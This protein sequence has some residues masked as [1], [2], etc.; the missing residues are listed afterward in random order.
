[1]LA[2][3]QA[4]APELADILDLFHR[5]AGQW[6]H[7]PGD[8]HRRRSTP[9]RDRVRS[10]I[11][12]YRPQDIAALRTLL[13]KIKKARDRK[14]RQR[15][16]LYRIEGAME[17]DVVY[18]SEDL[19]VRHIKNKQASIHYGHDTKWCISMTRDGY[20][21]EYTSHNATFFFFERKTPKRDAFDKVALL[22]PRNPTG[23][24]RAVGQAFDALD[25]QIDMFDLAEVHG[26][27]IFDILRDVYERSAQYPG[28]P[29]ACVYAGTA[30]TEQLH[31]VFESVV[32]GQVGDYDVDAVLE[33]ICCNDAAPWS[34]LEEVVIRAR[35][36]A[37]RRR[38]SVRRYRRL[39]TSRTQ[40]AARLLRTIHAALVIHPNAPADAR[41][42]I[43]KQ[44]RRSH[45]TLAFI[46]RVEGERVGVTFELPRAPGRY[47]RRER[48]NT[49][50]QLR[51]RA[52]MYDSRAARYRKKAR[53]LQRK[54]TEKAR[55][56]A[57]KKEKR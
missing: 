40:R 28:S 9:Q 42:V 17:A 48:F 24:R 14:Q 35:Y 7:P 11:Y 57:K 16:K 13:G 22:L 21:D 15:E 8:A 25:Q 34:L 52:E 45:V 53:T 46:R 36:I 32:G 26:P 49:P 3:G 38:R 47:R 41:E 10:D 6:Y 1:M 23:N 50:A 2:S 29:M 37:L 31:T 27:R 56:G 18:D 20:F 44:L 19:I 51:K 12:S 5:F 4:L 55:K 33:A 39:R 54:L 43:T 30:T